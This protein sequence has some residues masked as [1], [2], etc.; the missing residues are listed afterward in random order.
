MSIKEEKSSAKELSEAQKHIR[1]AECRSNDLATELKHVSRHH[2]DSFNYF[3]DRGLESIAESMT[4][5]EIHATK[6]VLDQMEDKKYF[7]PFKKLKIAIPELRLGFP[8]KPSDLTDD[9]KLYP[10]E[11]RAMRS[12]YNAPLMASIEITIDDSV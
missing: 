7:F 2:V 1:V 12:S 9:S 3:I 4:P 5:V 8:S 11:C 6:K 10:Y